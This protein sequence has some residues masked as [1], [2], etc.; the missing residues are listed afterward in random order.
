[1][2]EDVINVLEYRPVEFTHSKLKRENTLKKKKVLIVRDL[3]DKRKELTFILSV[4]QEE[5]R[6]KTCVI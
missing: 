2:T 5:R 6:E 3:Q 4:S 1:M